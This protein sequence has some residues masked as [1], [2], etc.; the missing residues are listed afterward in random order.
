MHV[1]EVCTPGKAFSIL[2]CVTCIAAVLSRS[3]KESHLCAELTDLK[4]EIDDKH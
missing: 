3:G 1:F 4:L 2:Q